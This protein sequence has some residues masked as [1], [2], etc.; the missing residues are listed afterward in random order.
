MLAM[1]VTATVL[2]PPAPESG[3]AG[4]AVGSGVGVANGVAVGPAKV[5]LPGGVAAGAA[6]TADRGIL[7]TKRTPFPCTPMPGGPAA[8]GIAENEEEPWPLHPAIKN[9]TAATAQYRWLFTARKRSWGAVRSPPEGGRMEPT[10]RIVLVRHGYV[11][12][13]QPERFR[14]R[15]DLELTHQ[16]VEQAD[17]AAK[18]IA[19]V[20]R[21]VTIYTSPLRRCIVTGAAIAR[22]CGVN[23]KV[24]ESLTDINY[25]SWQWKTPDEARSR[26]PQ[27]VDLWLTRPDLVR[28]PSGE[29]LQDVA[30]RAAD[31]LR[32]VREQNVGQTVVLVT[33]DAVIRVLLLQLL[34]MP[35]SAYRRFDVDPGSISEAAVTGE[36]VRLERL[37]ESPLSF[38][39]GP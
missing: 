34:Q 17:A 2:V 20:W 31:A 10:T 26:W 15:T 37:N 25:G 27:L 5:E 22:A 28:V 24:L 6:L 4:V 23:A 30:V 39:T 1:P 13:I 33:H 29:S 18:R 9:A 8:G 11:E 21:P 32:H 38:Q 7:T 16:G 12:G 35:L 3:T 14:G 19:R 36:F